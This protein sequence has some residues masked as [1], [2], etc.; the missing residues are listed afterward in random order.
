MSCWEKTA[1]I[2]GWNA[3]SFP[4]YFPNSHPPVKSLAELFT[5][6]LGEY[7]SVVSSCIN[8]YLLGSGSKRC[9]FFWLLENHQINIRGL[10][11]APNYTEHLF[12]TWVDM[13]RT[14]LFNNIVVNN[15]WNKKKTSRKV[16]STTSFS[17]KKY[18]APTSSTHTCSRVQLHNYNSAIF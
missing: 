4:F 18:L 2:R 14:W 3:H 8:Y 10:K 7:Y 9:F 1:F 6:A 17:I 13:E 11:C 15:S 5:T 16:S 12:T